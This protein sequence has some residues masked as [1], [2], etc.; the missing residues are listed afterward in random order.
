L[1]MMSRLS[2][3]AIILIAVACNNS[4]T[5]TT[6]ELIPN[7]TPTTFDDSKVVLSKRYDSNIIDD[8]FNEATNKNAGLKSIVKRIE[9]IGKLKSDSLETYNKYSQ[10]TNRYLN[11]FDDYINQINDS[12]IKNDLKS[13]VKILKEKHQNAI[14]NHEK[15]IK[16]LND[17]NNA[18]NDYEIIMK[19]IVTEPMM[20]NYMRNELPDIRTIKSLIGKYDTLIKD[21]KPYTIINK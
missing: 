13:V 14:A 20:N 19:L 4:K 11:N 16:I 7:E 18:L 2:L 9:D 6:N 8:L 12:T 1:I 21:M 10:T 5:D 17:K 3:L 15:S